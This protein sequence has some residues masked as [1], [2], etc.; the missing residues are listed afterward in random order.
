[1]ESPTRQ[2]LTLGRELFNRHEYDAA[3]HHLRE[4]VQLDPDVAEAHN[5]LGM[6]L[7]ERGAYAEARD[8]FRR[9]TASAPTYTEAA[10]NLAITCNELGLYSEARKV[11]EDISAAARSRDRMD[12]FARSRLAALIA[13]VANG[14]EDLGLYDEAVEEYRKALALA[15]D[16]AEIRTRLGVLLRADG[17][18]DAACTELEQAVAQSPRYTP[19]RVALGLTLYRLGRAEEA[20]KVWRETLAVDPQNRPAAVY[21]RMLRHRE[22]ELPSVIPARAS[23]APSDEEF[24]NLEITVLRDRE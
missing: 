12:P 2:H 1:M 6:I 18:L 13:S 20:E 9:A 11:S 3:E 23:E 8:C 5:M 24:P 17:Q 16:L 21:L 7:H 10:L 15:P 19:A 14:Y 4:I 22:V